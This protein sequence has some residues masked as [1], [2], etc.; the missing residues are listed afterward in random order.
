[1]V[2]DDTT[3]ATKRYEEFSIE[4][5]DE[6][7]FVVFFLYSV[8][9][10]L[11]FYYSS[12]HFFRIQLIFHSNSSF[13]IFHLCRLNVKKQTLDGKWNQS[14]I[15]VD[16]CRLLSLGNANCVTFFAH[17]SNLF[18]IWTDAYAVPANF[19]E[20]DVVNPMTTITAGKKRYTEYEVL[21]RVSIHKKQYDLNVFH[22]KNRVSSISMIIVTSECQLHIATWLNQRPPLCLSHPCAYFNYLCTRIRFIIAAQ[23]STTIIDSFVFRSFVQLITTTTMDTRTDQLARIQGE[24]VQ[25]T[26]AL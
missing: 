2:E 11:I 25:R 26:P 20:I 10:F 23:L 6:V 17:G 4:S 24:R 18:I 7:T 5:I 3:D 16:M 1:M 15:S 12:H 14:S 9:L 13:F 19:L 8:I 22:T 21:M